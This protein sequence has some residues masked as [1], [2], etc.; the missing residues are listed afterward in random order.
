MYVLEHIPSGWLL[1]LR[2]VSFPSRAVLCQICLLWAPPS[3]SL[4]YY[5]LYFV[6]IIVICFWLCLYLSLILH[7][8]TSSGNEALI[9]YLWQV[10][11]REDISGTCGYDRA[12]GCPETQSEVCEHQLIIDWVL[13]INQLMIGYD[14]WPSIVCLLSINQFFVI[15]Q[16]SIHVLP[17]SQSCPSLTHTHTYKHTHTHMHARKCTHTTHI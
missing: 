16:W 2:A 5:K 1:L 7:G 8:V 11:V 14:Q 10:S 15:D 6:T 12:R 13:I 3:G 4:C 17:Y 9:L